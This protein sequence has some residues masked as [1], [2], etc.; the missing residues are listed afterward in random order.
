VVDI[1]FGDRQ[2]ISLIETDRANETGFSEAIIKACRKRL[3]FLR[4][5]PDERLLR[6]WKSLH[7]EKYEEVVPGGK[8]IRLNDQWRLVFLLDNDCK[9]PKLTILSI[10]D[11]H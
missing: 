6:A 5:A 8:S 11:Y 4:N 9:P 1:E 3:N 10:E 7:Y 2:Q